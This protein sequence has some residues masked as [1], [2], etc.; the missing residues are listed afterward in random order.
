MEAGMRLGVWLVVAFAA[1]CGGR[2]GTAAVDGGGAHAIHDD[3]NGTYTVALDRFTVAAGEER[4]ACQD[5]ANPFGGA[6]A[7]IR[8]F[9]S[10]QTPGSHHLL[11]FYK[12]GAQ[13][14]PLQPCSGTEFAAGPYGSQRAED[15]IAYPDG[16]AAVVAPADGFRVQV[17]YLNATPAP[18]DVAVTVTM[19]RVP[20]DVVR[21]RAG[22]LFFSNAAI[23]VAPGAVGAVVAKTCTLPFAVNLLQATGHMHA[24]GRAFAATANGATLFAAQ[25]SAEVTPALFAPPLPLA[26]GTPIRFACTYDN[27]GA[28]PLRYGDSARSDEMCIFTAQFYPAPFGGWTCS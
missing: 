2:A 23:D 12:A 20:G 5:F 16:V 9:A 8:R 10:Q 25:A 14:A 17:H 4:Y 27:D 26:A 7:A 6:A 15:A 24:H 11:V 22:I 19:E 1:G 18:I 3:G 13:D 28:T 21:D